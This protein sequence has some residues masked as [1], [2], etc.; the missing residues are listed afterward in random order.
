MRDDVLATD[1]D[2]LF[3][4]Q[5]ALGYDVTQT[6]F[7][8]R[9]TLLVEGPGDVLF[10]KALSE[11]LRHRERVHLDRRW[12]ICPAGGIDK[13]QSFVSL[14]SGAISRSLRSPIC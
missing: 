10:L 9:N 2:T 1:P 14:F 11:Q 12:T 7:I 3:P 8:G 13:I 4:L 5:G 6:L